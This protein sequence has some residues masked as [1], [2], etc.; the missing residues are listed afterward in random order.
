MTHMVFRNGDQ[1]K[2]AIAHQKNVQVVR[3]QWVDQC[4]DF[5]LRVPEGE[6]LIHENIA[7]TVSTT[8]D[9]KRSSNGRKSMETTSNQAR[10]LASP[11]D[12]T[13]SSSQAEGSAKP[14]RKR[15]RKVV[16]AQPVAM[17][18]VTRSSPVSSPEPSGTPNSERRRSNR[19]K[20]V[21]S[22]PKSD[23]RKVRCTSTGTAK[24]DSPLRDET[25]IGELGVRGTICKSH[26][27]IFFLWAAVFLVGIPMIARGLAFFR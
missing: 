15:E 14:Q 4:R 2:L 16:K 22:G 13:F 25:Q 24:S 12:P 17:Q 21:E 7:A 11:G 27:Y 23:A 8:G 20:G 5:L 1:D 3:P 6:F 18:R 26:K 9:K 19:A 10:L